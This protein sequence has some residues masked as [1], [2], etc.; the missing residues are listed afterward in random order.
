MNSQ[1]LK[2][3][4]KGL[5]SIARFILIIVCIILFFKMCKFSHEGKDTREPLRKIEIWR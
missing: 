2:A 5:T 4:K 1:T 3:M